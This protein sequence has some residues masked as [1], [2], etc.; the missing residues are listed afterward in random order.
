MP[1]VI[2]DGTTVFG[3]ATL[4]T[5]SQSKHPKSWPVQ[6]V[7]YVEVNLSELTT[8]HLYIEFD[9]GIRIVVASDDQIPLAAKLIGNLRKLANSTSSGGR[10]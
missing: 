6:D 10:S 4:K 1:P 2:G 9:N 7:R 5:M 8:R 3:R